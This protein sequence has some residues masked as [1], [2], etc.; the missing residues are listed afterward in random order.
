VVMLFVIPVDEDSHPFA[1]LLQV[2]EGPLRESR[3]VL[4]GLEQ[5]LRIGVGSPR[6]G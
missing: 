1:C 3:G 4:A 6:G 5:G 2:L